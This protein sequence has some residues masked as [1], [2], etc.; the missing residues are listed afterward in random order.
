MSIYSLLG[1]LYIG[2]LLLDEGSW[3]TF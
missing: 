3:S 2:L 1:V